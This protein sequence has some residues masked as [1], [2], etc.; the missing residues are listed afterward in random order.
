M[1]SWMM[2][3]RVAGADELEGWQ[4]ACEAASG[5]RSAQVSL[6]RAEAGWRAGLGAIY[7]DWLSLGVESGASVG[8]GPVPVSVGTRVS[9]DLARTRY[10]EYQEIADGHTVI[11]QVHSEPLSVMGTIASRFGRQR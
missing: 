3:A 6:D 1:W 9:H 10:P 4:E 11:H 8:V 2:W 7:E 5:D